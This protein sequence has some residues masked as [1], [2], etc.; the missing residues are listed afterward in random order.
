M[1]FSW[2]TIGSFSFHQTGS[3]CGKHEAFK[4]SGAQQKGFRGIFIFLSHL[5]SPGSILLSLSISSSLTFIH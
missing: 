3:L 2:D 5:L 4:I 1:T